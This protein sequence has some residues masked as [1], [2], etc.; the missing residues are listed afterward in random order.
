M[1]ADYEIQPHGDA[2]LLIV[3]GDRIDP[4]ISRRVHAAAAAV[5]QARA[6]AGPWSTPIPAYASLL[7]G[8][9][10]SAV[11]FDAARRQLGG[12]LDGVDV[13][14]DAGERPADTIEIPVRYG[15]EDGPDLDVVAERC[16]LTP[17][18]V[19]ELHASETYLA[20]ML[21]FAPGFAYLGELPAAL[22]LPRRDT[23]RQRVPAGSVA[24]AGRQT[25]VYPAPTPGGWHLLGR[26]DVTVWDATRTPPALIQPGTAVRFV[27]DA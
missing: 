1:T 10:A 5:R 13:D 22:E 21:G 23:P 20:Y 4:L 17:A 16:A 15:G 12:I 11:D 7:V 19:I 24:I 2:A 25:A 18:Q 9:D 6:Q 14:R 27:P 8:Y 3:F 26:T